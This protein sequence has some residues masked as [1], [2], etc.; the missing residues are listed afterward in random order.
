MFELQLQR[1]NHIVELFAK[2]QHRRFG[3]VNLTNNFKE[4][5]EKEGEGMIGKRR[6]KT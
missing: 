6:L 3:D 1:L 4:A 5:N 2:V